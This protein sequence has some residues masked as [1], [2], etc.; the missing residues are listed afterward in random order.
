MP[1]IGEFAPFVGAVHPAHDDLAARAIGGD[2][3]VALPHALREVEESLCKRLEVRSVR[4]SHELLE[5][6][7]WRAFSNVTDGPV[8]DRGHA[9]R[10]ALVDDLAALAGA[11]EPEH[12]PTF[13]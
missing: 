7:R 1:G 2:D 13:S 11:N 12:A 5:H 8:A 10:H 4:R 9:V 6:L 3:V